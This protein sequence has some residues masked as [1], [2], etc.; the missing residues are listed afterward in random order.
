M[1]FLDFLVLF[2]CNPKCHKLSN[3]IIFNMENS[4]DLFVLLTLI[5]I[6]GQ[7]K[8]MSYWYSALALSLMN[9][10][11]FLLLTINTTDYH[12]T[13]F[14]CNC[15]KLTLNAI[16]ASWVCDNA[17]TCQYWIHSKISCN[18]LLIS[19]KYSFFIQNQ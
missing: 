3:L 13:E 11:I 2:A 8:Y 14:Y 15:R 12:Q 5:F 4:I 9:G 19:K 10:E 18:V 6:I 1:L 16:F 7:W 17:K